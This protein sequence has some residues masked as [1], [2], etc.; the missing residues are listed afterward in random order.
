[1]ALLS[2]DE[3][4]K[5]MRQFPGNFLGVFPM[6]RLPKTVIR[7][8]PFCFIVNTDHHGFPGKHWIAIYGT[9]THLDV[10]DPL[11]GQLPSLLTRWIFKRYGNNW[12]TNKSAYQFAL[13]TL[14]GAYCIWYLLH[15]FHATSMDHVLIRLFPGSPLINDAIIHDYFRKTC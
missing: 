2:T 4:A 5:C 8:Y 9:R 7:I 15:R 1:M 10:F 13:S 3:I 14:C 6:N 12:K 11:S